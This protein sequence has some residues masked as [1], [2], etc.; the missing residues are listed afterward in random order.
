M[1]SSHRGLCGGGRGQGPQGLTLPGPWL[2]AGPRGSPGPQEPRPHAGTR[3]GSE[4]SAHRNL[5]ADTSIL[6]ILTARET[7]FYRLGYIQL[8][9]PVPCK[10][11]C[12]TLIQLSAGLGAHSRGGWETQA[13]TRAWGAAS[14]WGSG[15]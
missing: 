14:L 4:N 5:R 12:I 9:S 13:Q 2:P 7:V 10:V 6:C 11:T 3:P 15:R 1:D 8:T